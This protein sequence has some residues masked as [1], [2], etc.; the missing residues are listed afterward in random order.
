[1]LNEL[2]E[3]EIIS[4][5]DEVPN[6]K[7][8]IEEGEGEEEEELPYNL[9]EYHDYVEQKEEDWAFDDEFLNTEI[10]SQ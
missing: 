3:I 10:E 7:L 6:E 2:S 4:V 1:M 9:G 5:P 8:E